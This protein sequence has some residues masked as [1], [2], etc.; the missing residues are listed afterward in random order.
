MKLTLEMYFQTDGD[1]CFLDPNHLIHLF[2]DS[3]LYEDAVKE[4]V[5]D[6]SD[7][8]YIHILLNCEGNPN[9]CRWAA[10]DL[11][12][13]LVSDGIRVVHYWLVKNLYNLLITPDEEILWSE[14][15]VHYYDSIDGNYEGT[16]LKLDIEH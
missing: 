12:E 13:H 7:P 5:Y 14:E 10:R 6:D 1:F 16:E 8:Y 9:P 15:D 3:P 4:Y 11:L 2:E